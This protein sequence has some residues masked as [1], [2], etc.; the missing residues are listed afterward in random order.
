MELVYIVNT[1]PYFDLEVFDTYSKA[2]NYL[3][4]V[5][6]YLDWEYNSSRDEYISHTG[7]IFYV[8]TR[9]VK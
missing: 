3:A 6:N 5:G 7:E 4:K 9:E 1:Y 2:S 8:L